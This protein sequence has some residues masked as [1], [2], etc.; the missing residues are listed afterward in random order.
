MD[1]NNICPTLLTLLWRRRRE[2]WDNWCIISTMLHKLEDT[3]LPYIH[4]LTG[5]NPVFAAATAFLTLPTPQPSLSFFFLASCF[6]FFLQG[7]AYV[8]QACRILV[9]WP[10]IKLMPP[11]LW[12]YG[13]LT[14]GL[15]GMSPFWC[16]YSYSLLKKKDCLHRNRPS[17]SILCGVYNI[18]QFILTGRLCLTDFHWGT[19][20]NLSFDLGPATQ[21]RADWFTDSFNK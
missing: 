9:P 6:F 7:G 12:K 14:T 15:P 1:V 11:L 16:L 20:V 19:P 2:E 10:G 4:C 18:L 3:L 17:L 5:M 8:V 21:E 13:I